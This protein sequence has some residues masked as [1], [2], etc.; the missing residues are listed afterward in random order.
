M[1]V[2]KMDCFVITF[3]AMTMIS[4]GALAQTVNVKVNGLVCSFCAT[5]L[6]KTFGKK[7][8]EDIDVNLDEKYVRFELSEDKEMS[9]EEI[10]QTINDA[11]YDVKGIERK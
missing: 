9:D 3:L 5:A 4:F 2:I 7:G 1:C 6:E 10:T 11:G 8:V